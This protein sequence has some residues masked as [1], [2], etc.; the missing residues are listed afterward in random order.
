LV[1]F[2]SVTVLVRGGGDLASGA[3]YRLVKAGFPVIVTELACPLAIRR[4][5]AF[6]S[7]VFDGEITVE[8][9]TARRADCVDDMPAIL[10]AGE[11]PV[12]V[13]EAGASLPTI[14]PAVLVD[15]RMAK[16]NLGTTI[17]DAPLVI[18]LGR[19]LRRAA[20]AMPSLRPIAGTSWGA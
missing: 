17:H 2:S 7:A 12:L 8:G 9:L 15:A 18:A 6:A 5:V 19:V 11:I 14:H 13:D 1:L 16:R 10:A 3:I 4:T 20:T